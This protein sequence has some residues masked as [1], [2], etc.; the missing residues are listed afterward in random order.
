MRVL[1]REEFVRSLGAALEEALLTRCGLSAAQA[2][3]LRWEILRACLERIRARSRRVRGLSRSEFLRQ[4]QATHAELLQARECAAHELEDVRSRL[5]EARAAGLAPELD[6]A[7]EQELEHSLEADLRALLG[8]ADAAAELPAVLERERTRRRA[9]MDRLLEAQ[10]RRIDVLE[11]RL[12]KLRAAVE[13][14][15]RDLSELARR[16]ELDS[17]LPSIY[18]GVQGLVAESPQREWKGALLYSIFQQNLAL[19][20]R[21][22]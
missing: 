17:G 2:R 8:S 11:R 1:T 7:V 10:R 6:A 9:A 4:L 20:R 13:Q 3:R 15:E 19:Q 21:S 14:M 5:V 22:A 18:R 12:T 16:A